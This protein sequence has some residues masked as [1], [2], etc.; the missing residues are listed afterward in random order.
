MPGV[1]KEWR[2]PGLS[3]CRNGVFCGYGR[4]NQNREKRNVYEMGAIGDQ[5]LQSLS[6]R[7]QD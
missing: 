4:K 2:T 3:C 7:M 5:S 6:Q 1:E